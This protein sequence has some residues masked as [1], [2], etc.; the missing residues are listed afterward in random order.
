MEGITK[1]NPQR[2]AKLLQNKNDHSITKIGVG[3]RNW[4]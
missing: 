1:E 2:N 3:L 4:K